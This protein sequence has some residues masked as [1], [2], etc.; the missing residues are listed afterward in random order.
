M[1]I[2]TSWHAFADE[3]TRTFPEMRREVVLTHRGDMSALTR[4]IAQA[5]DLTFAEAAE[6]VTFRLPMYLEPQRGAA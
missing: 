6:V 5:H 2:A 3:V 4:L 1:S